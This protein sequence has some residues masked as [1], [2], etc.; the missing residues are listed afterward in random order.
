MFE[1]KNRAQDRD[2][3]IILLS[4]SWSRWRV[5]RSTPGSSRGILGRMTCGG[6]LTNLVMCWAPQY[7]LLCRLFCNTAAWTRGGVL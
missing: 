6:L 4:H 7:Q 2:H 1:T 3:I 5:P